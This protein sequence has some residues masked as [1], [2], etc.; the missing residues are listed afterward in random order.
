L[1]KCGASTDDC[2]EI[3]MQTPAAYNIATS[4]NWLEIYKQLSAK[5]TL[6][7]TGANISADYS[8]YKS[9]IMSAVQGNAISVLNYIVEEQIN[10]YK[11]ITTDET[12]LSESEIK[13][14]KK[15]I[16]H[17][18]AIALE[19]IES[20]ITNALTYQRLEAAELLIIAKIKLQA[21]SG[22][23]PPHVKTESF[24]SGPLK[25]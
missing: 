10:P 24:Q 5:N 25:K 6:A 11:I 2:K 23:R 3:I 19:Y 17:L 20:G 21:L 8:R 9:A 4:K 16:K 13:E 7:V 1:Q 18:T 12:D 14:R 22:Q 15:K